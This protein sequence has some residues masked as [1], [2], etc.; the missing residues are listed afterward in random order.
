MIDELGCSSAQFSARHVCRVL[1]FYDSQSVPL[2][3]IIFTCSKR[4][5]I[6]FSYEQG[7]DR[8]GGSCTVIG[9]LTCLPTQQQEMRLQRVAKVSPL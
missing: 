2:E 3:S 7:P 1:S 9:C 5:S 6:I 8:F 4:A